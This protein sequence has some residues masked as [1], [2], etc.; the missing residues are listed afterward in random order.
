[1]KLEPRK[2]EAAFLI[3]RR[4]VTELDIEIGQT[5]I[6]TSNSTKNLGKQF[7]R[8]TSMMSHIRKVTEKA[9]KM[10][11]ALSRIMPNIGS[12]QSSKRRVLVLVV[13]FILL[14]GVPRRYG[15]ELCKKR[16]IRD[17]EEKPKK[18]IA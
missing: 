6:R 17:G 14:Y 3:G 12:V 13:H 5:R 7:K 16:N 4:D 15:N 8:N 11:V 2:T 18:S 10:T 9:E 1:M